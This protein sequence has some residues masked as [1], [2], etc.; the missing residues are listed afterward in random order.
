MDAPPANKKKCLECSEPKEYAKIF[1]ELFARVSIKNFQ[2]YFLI[3]IEIFIIII[4][5]EPK[6]FFLSKSFISGFSCFKT[7]IFIQIK[8]KKNKRIFMCSLNG[9]TGAR[10]SIIRDRG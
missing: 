2:Q 10:E 3:Y 7:Y 8:K 9:S 6:F 1:F 5:L 4:P